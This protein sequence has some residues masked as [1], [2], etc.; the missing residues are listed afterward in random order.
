MSTYVSRK[1]MQ[2]DLG[3]EDEEFDTAIKGL[4]KK[5]LMEETVIGN[6]PHYRITELGKMIFSHVESDNTLRN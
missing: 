5:E 1:Q 6:E 2:S 4:L 3:I